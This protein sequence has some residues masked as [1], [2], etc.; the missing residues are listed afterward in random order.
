M[1]VFCFKQKTAYEMLRSL[2]GSE[3]CIRDRDYTSG[4]ETVLLL[5]YLVQITIVLG[6]PSLW[7]YLRH[8]E[9][10]EMTTAL[11]AQRRIE[12]DAFWTQQ[13]PHKPRE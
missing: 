1:F 12:T 11:R 7:Y 2:V 6:V 9:Q 4:H 10:W 13:K 5:V 8:R 3:M